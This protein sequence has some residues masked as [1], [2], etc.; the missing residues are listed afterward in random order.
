M[1]DETM[2]LAIAFLTFLGVLISWWQSRKNTA[3]IQE[4]HVIVNNRLTELLHETGKSARAAGIL[5]GQ[6]L[7]VTQTEEKAAEVLETAAETARELKSET[8]RV[9]IEEV[10]VDVQVKLEDKKTNVKSGEKS[11]W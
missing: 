6:N 2:K 9:L 1:N 4:L 7:K 10:P 11:R 8:A 5:E 3:K